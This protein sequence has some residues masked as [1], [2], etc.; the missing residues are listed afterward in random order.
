MNKR[1]LR[2]VDI[3]FY[4]ALE[5]LVKKRKE[6]LKNVTLSSHMLFHRVLEDF[7]KDKGLYIKYEGVGP[8]GFYRGHELF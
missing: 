4:K 6:I 5:T 7:E 8:E 1:S 3:N 2:L